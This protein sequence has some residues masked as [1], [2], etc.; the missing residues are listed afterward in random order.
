MQ[1][2]YN[3]D[4][5]P[6][7]FGMV[8]STD[9]ITALTGGSPTV[10]ISK[11]GGA[12]AAPAGTVAEIG[13]GLYK[14]TPSGSDA[15]T[16]GMLLLHATATGGDPTDVAAQVV[17]FSPYDAVRLGLSAIPNAA[18]GASGG[19]PLGDSSG[20]ATLSGSTQTS[21]ATTV[22]TTPM[23]KAFLSPSTSSSWTLAGLLFSLVRRMFS[24][25]VSGTTETVYDF[26]NTTAVH[27]ITL[28]SST[29]PTSALQA[30]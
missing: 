27:T 9:H 19:V 20:N 22:F 2:I 1:L 30:S 3:G 16:N 6:I 21:I 28:N 17:A 14:L 13:D 10:T 26:D 23:T 4:A 18:A 12:Y 11:N 25:S 15:T 24:R 29:S 7:T 8:S 5:K